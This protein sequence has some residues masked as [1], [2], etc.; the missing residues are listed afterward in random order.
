MKRIYPIFGYSLKCS[1][2]VFVC[3]KW[4]ILQLIVAFLSYSFENKKFLHF[5]EDGFDFGDNFNLIYNK[6]NFRITSHC[7]KTRIDSVK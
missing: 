3:A 7:L 2:R 4:E 5:C 1:K 6:M